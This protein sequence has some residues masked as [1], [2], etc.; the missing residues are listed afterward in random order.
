MQL[1][2]HFQKEEF[3]KDGP[4]PEECV[5]SYRSLCESILEP[6]RLHIGQPLR[7]TS[8]YRT[9][10][11]NA[12]AGGVSSSQH[13]ATDRWCAADWWE[14]ST[15]MREVFDW[16]RLQSGLKFDQLIL[17]HDGGNLCIIHT[18]WSTTP[19][20]MALEGATANRTGYISWPVTGEK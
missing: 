6:I 3:E 16:I 7:I 20:R 10:A 9:P 15:N 14:P 17:E 8:G 1:S 13:C 11:S 5:G 19:R 2:E 4:M 12:V 18:S